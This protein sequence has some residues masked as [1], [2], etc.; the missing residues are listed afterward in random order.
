M[1][2][3]HSHGPFEPVAKV[4]IT[5]LCPAAKGWHSQA[6]VQLPSPLSLCIQVSMHHPRQV[7]AS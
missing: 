3:F 4:G 6:G 5:A 1:Y 7:L 2:I